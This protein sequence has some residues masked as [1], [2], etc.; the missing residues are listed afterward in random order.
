MIKPP[1]TLQELRRKIYVKAKSESQWKFW[2]L[3]VHIC[4]LET[5]REAYSLAKCNK[6]APGIDGVTFAAIE[7]IGVEQYLQN[8]REE[9]LD[10]TY[11][12]ARNRKMAIPKSTRGKSRI[13][14]IPN[15]RDRIIQGAVKLII[16]PIFEADFQEGSYGYRPKR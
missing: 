16:E 10:E 14:S 3:Y 5:L 1:I 2:G 7:A 8:L 15:I 4:K 11:K 12:P 6:G 9:L 13:L